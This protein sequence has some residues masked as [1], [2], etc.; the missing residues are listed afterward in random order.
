M[1]ST[2]VDQVNA[3][4]L[5]L[6]EGLSIRKVAAQV[7]ISAATVGRIAQKRMQDQAGWTPG[8]AGRPARLTVTDKRKIVRDITSGKCDNAVQ[9]TASL[10]SDA[11]VVV[12]VRTVR[13]AL[14]ESG[15]RAAPKVKKPLLSQRHHKARLEFAIRHKDWTVDDWRK[16]VWSDETKINRLGSDGREWCWKSRGEALSNRTCNP[17]VK[18]GGGSLM[19]WGCMTAKGIGHLTKIEGNMDAELY[20]EILRDELMNSLEYRDLNVADVLFQQDNDPKHTS[21]KAKECLKELGFNILQWPAQSPDLNPI[22]HLWGHLK[23]CLNAWPT[24]PTGILDLW[25]RVEVEWEGIPLDV[26]KKLIDS[27]PR[28][29]AAVLKA[30]GGMTKY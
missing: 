22:E 19:V 15:L 23:R 21:K 11:G 30:K 5:L 13:R 24:Q 17:T 26:I 14:R 9:A 28:R 2:S 1:K 16:V 27:M 4:V 3:V 6:S 10:A 20:C 8:R 7:S 29:V 18:H 12:N 25:E